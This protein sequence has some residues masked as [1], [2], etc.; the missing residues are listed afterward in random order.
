MELPVLDAVEQ[1][2]L[3]SLLEKQRTVPATYPLTLNSLRL[4]CNQSSSRDPVVEYDEP[5]LEAALKELRHRELIRVVWADTGRRTLKYHQLLDELL[6]LQPDERALITVLLLRG[7][8]SAGELKTRT[9]R[10]HGFADR[11]E[12]EQCL[13]RLAGLPT[14]LV[15][16]LARRAGQ[17]DTRWIHLLG[18]VPEAAAAAPVAPAV[19]REEVLAGGAQARDD[20]VVATYDTVAETYA[21]MNAGEWDGGYGDPGAFERW[22]VRRFAACVGDRGPVLDLG[23]GPA[24]VTAQLAALGLE[25]SGLDASPGMVAEAARRYPEVPVAVG[26][27]RRLLK[28]PTAVGWAGLL[29]RFSLQHLA[30]SEWPAVLTEWT[31]V[32]APGGALA[33]AVLTGEEIRRAEEWLGHEVKHEVVLHEA[34]WVV[35]ALARAGL[36]DIEIYQRGPEPGTS[37]TIDR[38]YFL[39]RKPV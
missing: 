28:P 21:G 32:L 1:R 24:H 9:D 35:E 12:V 4:A 2:I 10:L 16:E 34:S 31:R 33:L 19:D 11:E 36:V 26:D 18:P 39:A 17:H 20:R 14:P 13:Q 22:F 38:A 8:Q 6:G 37:E 23:C 15:R 29:S 3:G 25:A 30:P 27:F 5:L 7:A